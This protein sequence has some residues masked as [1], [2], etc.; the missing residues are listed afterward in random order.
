[1][2][3]ELYTGNLGPILDQ[4]VR[5]RAR[6]T[7]I[8]GPL[9]SG[10]TV[11]SCQKLM[12]LM[13]EQRP[14]KR[15][16][17]K[18]RWI[19][20]RNTFPDLQTTTIKDW[21]ELFDELGTFKGG[22]IAPPT[23]T[24]HFRLPDRTVVLSELIFLALDRPQAIKKLRGTQVTGFWL[25]ELKELEKAVVDMADLRHGRY[26]SP[27]DGGPSW[28]GMIGDTNSPDDDHWLYELAEITKP[29]G[30][31]FY[32]QPG[33]LY[34]EMRVVRPATED[35]AALVEWTGRWLPNF[36]AENLSNLPDGYYIKGMQGKSTDWIAVNLANEYGTVHTGKPVYKEQ[37]NSTLHVSD[38]ISLVKD[39]P[40]VVGLDFGLTPAAI[41]GQETPQGNINI[42]EEIIGEGMGV[43]QFTENLLLPA[44]RANYK[45]CEWNFVGDPAGEKRSETDESTVFKTLDELGISCEPANTNDIH[46]RLEAVR[47]FLQTLRNGRAGYQVHPRCKRLIKG[48]NG[49]Y[50]YVRIQAPGSEKYHSK[51][52]KDKY[53]H[54]HDANQ[55][56]CMY[57]KG[58]IGETNSEFEREDE[59]R[60]SS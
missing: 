2:R 10:K 48:F 14:N 35:E 55:Y 32:R 34:R 54:P 33:G 39:W 20:I 46:M 36:D 11:G 38:Q 19:A 58:D 44:L 9:G 57:F 26:P 59:S 24:L 18:T 53:S 52:N 51:P 23:H 4:Y 60:W 3:F 12:Q 42:L 25:N 5:S 56:L 40:I 49:G 28:H 27:I 29:E 15:G 37:W 31:E 21:R 47:Y 7:C 30:W 41:I 50:Q 22:G 17:R 8:T 45:G 13:T 1:M 6:V 43:Q 16:Q